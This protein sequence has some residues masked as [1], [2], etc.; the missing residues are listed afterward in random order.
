MSFDCDK[1]YTTVSLISRY[2][3]WHGAYALQRGLACVKFC[4]TGLE[5][6][7][8][9]N[10][11]CTKHSYVYFSC[12]VDD[13]QN[14]DVRVNAYFY[15]KLIVKCSTF[16]FAYFAYT[17]SLKHETKPHRKGKIIVF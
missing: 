7:I 17:T 11:Y 1:H 12:L 14:A 5:S 16:C 15:G 10:L 6:R 8:C 13:Y 2:S 9:V 3:L 4:S